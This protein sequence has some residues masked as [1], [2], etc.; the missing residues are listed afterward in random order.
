MK[1]GSMQ[2][3]SS[4]FVWFSYLLALNVHSEGSHSSQQRCPFKNSLTGHKLFL[5]FT[6]RPVWP[7]EGKLPGFLESKAEIRQK[8]SF[9]KSVQKNV[10]T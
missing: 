7:A 9:N 2:K 6:R 3:A 4:F 1:A 8:I 10:M 5:Y